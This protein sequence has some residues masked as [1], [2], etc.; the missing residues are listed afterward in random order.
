MR[1]PRGSCRDR[2]HLRASQA[3]TQSPNNNKPQPPT[4]YEP[5]GFV[6]GRSLLI[7][8]VGK[9]QRTLL[10]AI[11]AGESESD[12]GTAPPCGRAPMSPRRRG[13]AVKALA[14]RAASLCKSRR[15]ISRLRWTASA[16][17]M[18]DGSD[19]ELER[20]LSPEDIARV[21]GLSRRAVYRAIARGE[22]QAVRLCHRLRIRPA[23]LERW[24]GGRA[25][26]PESRSP[27]RRNRPIAVPPRG[28]LRSILNDVDGQGGSR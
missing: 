14:P 28:S 19:T 6:P 17:E 8:N 22:L 24:I 23:E 3:A 4:H 25:I 1:Q 2:P 26:F 9:V 27:K 13:R 18:H 11:S 15:C 10:A 7:Q 16:E 21:C 12:F 5:S 20:L